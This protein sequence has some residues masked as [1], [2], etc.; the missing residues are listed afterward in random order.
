MQARLDKIGLAFFFFALLGLGL[1]AKWNTYSVGFAYSKINPQVIHLDLPAYDEGIGGL[2]TADVNGDGRRDFIITKP[3]HIAVYDN[4]GKKLWVK[5]T[6]IQVTKKAEIYG[7]P[8][9]HGPGVQ[10]ADVDG[11]GHTEVLYLT[12]D[13]TLHAVAGFTGSLTQ[14][15]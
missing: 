14:C 13:G 15:Y 6:E 10:A 7:L 11:D 3:G 8:G 1:G 4:S 12:R 5:R 9:W 2:I